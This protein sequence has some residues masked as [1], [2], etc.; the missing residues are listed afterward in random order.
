MGRVALL[1][2]KDNILVTGAGHAEFYKL[3]NTLHADATANEEAEILLWTMTTW[4]TLSNDVFLEIT[5]MRRV[6]APNSQVLK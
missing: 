5:V 1:Q 2:A 4:T 6:K 3:T